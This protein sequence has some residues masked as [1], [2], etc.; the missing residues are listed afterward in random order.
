MYS[1]TLFIGGRLKIVATVNAPLIS[2]G[3]LTVNECLIYFTLQE[4]QN[5]YNNHQK[6]VSLGITG[7]LQTRSENRKYS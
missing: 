1:L 2:I 5:E 3:L 4:T 6:E 7:F